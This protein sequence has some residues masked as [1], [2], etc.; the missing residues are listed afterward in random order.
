MS[1]KT[2]TYACTL[3][4]TGNT[5]RGTADYG[6]Y[7]RNHVF[8]APGKPDLPGSSDPAFRGDKSRYNPEE[9][10][11]AAVASCHMLWYL[12]LCAD[13]GVVVQAYRD[14]PTGTMVEDPERGGYFT[15]ITLHPKVTI[16]KG[17]AVG[18]ARQLHGPAH[19]KCY[20]ANSVNFPVSCEPE[21]VVG[22]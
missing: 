12:H 10:L 22:Q 6:A 18:K 16:A 8:S 20:I 11:V 14:E 7:S 13:A 2:R 15:G 9:L 17:S 19:A 5:G 1:G 3:A 21:I 4:W